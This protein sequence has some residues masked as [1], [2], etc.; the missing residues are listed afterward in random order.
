M[1]DNALL[2]KKHDEHAKRIGDL[3]T[4][5][6]VHK[7]RLDQH[8]QEFRVMNS[9]STARHT[10]LTTTLGK[11]SDD[12]Q[13]FVKVYHEQQGQL[14]GATRVGKWGI[15]IILTLTGL[16]IAYIGATS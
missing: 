1:A 10:E 15:G 14:M 12:M 16:A 11:Y 9:E 4:V 13:E 7:E 3:E 8:T 6:R 2:W 5:S